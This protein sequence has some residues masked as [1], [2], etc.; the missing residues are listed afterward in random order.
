MDKGRKELA[1]PAA[2]LYLSST[3]VMPGFAA[4]AEGCAM[5][6]LFGL[7]FPL[8]FCAFSSFSDVRWRFRCSVRSCGL[9]AQG[10]AVRLGKKAP[11]PKA[12]NGR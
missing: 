4:A 7:S 11:G 10:V 8:P 3:A 6:L 1:V 9:Q 5:P 2:P 12:G